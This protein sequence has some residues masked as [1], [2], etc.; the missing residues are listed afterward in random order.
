MRNLL[1]P[2]LLLMLFTSAWSQGPAMNEK[3]KAQKVAFIT[4][5]LDLSEQEAQKFW[6]IYNA[7]DKKVEQIRKNDLREVR[8]A[9]RRGNLNPQ[10]AKQIL[11]QFM[12]VEDKLH[13]AKKKLVQDLL[14]VIPPQ[15]IIALKAAEDAFNKKLI[16]IL[17]EQRN[18][19]KQ[20]RQRN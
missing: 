16:Q 3:I 5:R 2:I 12:A 6:P 18:K 7:F 13:E 15:K 1:L 11:D 14:A 10:E 4:N 17:Q 19:M 9:M 8:V 20:I